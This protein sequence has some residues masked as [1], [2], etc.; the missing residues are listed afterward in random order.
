MNVIAELTLY[1]Y[2]NAW[3]RCHRDGTKCNVRRS[4]YKRIQLYRT[5]L[6]VVSGPLRIRLNRLVQGKLLIFR[7]K[8][9]RLPVKYLPVRPWSL[10]L[11]WGIRRNVVATSCTRR[12][13]LLFYRWAGRPAVV[14]P[15]NKTFRGCLPWSVSYEDECLCNF[16]TNLS[17]FTQNFS[18]TKERHATN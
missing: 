17:D 9:F 4:R 8:I 16:T 10:M 15:V 14:T 6:Q 3:K 1:A 13:W 2:W 12:L 5:D 18:L 11:A 7:A